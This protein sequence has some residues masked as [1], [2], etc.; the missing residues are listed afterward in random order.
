MTKTRFAA[1]VSG[2]MLLLALAPRPAGAQ[3]TSGVMFMPYAFAAPGALSQGPTKTL[4]VGGGF[5]ALFI[6]GF[7]V[8][9]EGG[10]LGPLP[11][12]FDYG[13]G[14]VS[15]NAVQHFGTPRRRALV[16]FVSGGYSLAFRSA[17]GH[18]LNVGGGVNYWF[19]DGVALRIELRDHLPVSDRGI[20]DA[21]LWGVRVGFT[22]R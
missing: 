17:I 12:G 14:V 20:A 8:S 2:A 9:V 18:G 13:I 3:T 1:A 7:G 21:H 6:Q 5:D 10:Y 16:P 19:S 22:W 4:H 15:T 11:D